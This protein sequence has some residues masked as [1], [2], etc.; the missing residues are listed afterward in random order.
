M[1]EAPDLSLRI[2]YYRA[3]RSIATTPVRWR[4]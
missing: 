4:G 2:L 1:Q 3:F